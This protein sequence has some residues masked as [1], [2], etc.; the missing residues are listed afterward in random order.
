[1]YNVRVDD[2]S[3]TEIATGTHLAVTGGGDFIYSR[4]GALY[5]MAAE[6]DEVVAGAT[7]TNSGGFHLADVQLQLGAG[8]VAV[9]VL[10]LVIPI[11]RLFTHRPTYSIRR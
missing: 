3:V 5:R 8:S 10:L 6:T 1:M 2:F 9:L 11:V 7:T 4:E